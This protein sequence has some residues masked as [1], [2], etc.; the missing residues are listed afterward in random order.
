MSYIFYSGRYECLQDGTILR[1][2][3]DSA[4]Y[5]Q[6]RKEETVYIFFEVAKM[7]HDF[8]VISLSFMRLSIEIR[9]RALQ[10]KQ[11]QNETHIF[12]TGPFFFLC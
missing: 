4:Y 6:A 8:T 12:R 7:E 2:R 3:K 5:W 11:L 10:M 1:Q 9:G